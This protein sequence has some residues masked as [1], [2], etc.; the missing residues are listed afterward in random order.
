MQMNL[1]ATAATIFSPVS[2]PPPP[3]IMCMWRVIS[4]APST[5]IGTSSTLLRSNTRMPSPLS[6]SVEALELDTAP[7][8]RPLIRASSSMK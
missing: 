6:R 7:S 2:A 1:R 5:Y 8:M 3:L 4:S